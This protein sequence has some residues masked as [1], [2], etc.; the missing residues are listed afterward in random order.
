MYPKSL[1]QQ[2]HTDSHYS[3]KNGRSSEL[4]EKHEFEEEAEESDDR[5]FIDD[6][7]VDESDSDAVIMAKETFAALSN[8]RKW[9]DSLQKPSCPLCA[10]MRVVLGHLL[11][12]DG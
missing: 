11:G 10:D 5:D 4:D 8:R 7:Q 3:Q 9:K 12:L 6:A 1:Y 2:Q